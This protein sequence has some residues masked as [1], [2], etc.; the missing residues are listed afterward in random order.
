MTREKEL[1][2]I[3]QKASPGRERANDGRAPSLR[4]GLD[5]RS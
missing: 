3:S 4:L 1:N 5:V 2:I